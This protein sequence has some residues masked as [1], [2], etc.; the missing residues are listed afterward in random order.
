[1]E[2]SNKSKLARWENV[3]IALFVLVVGYGLISLAANKRAEQKSCILDSVN[4]SGNSPGGVPI[5]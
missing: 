2:Q 3:C 1:M 5:E 4:E